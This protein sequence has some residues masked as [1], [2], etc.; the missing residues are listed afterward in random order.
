MLVSFPGLPIAQFFDHLTWDGKPGILHHV[1]SI[2]RQSGNSHFRFML[3]N[4]QGKIPSGENW[5]SISL[6]NG[7][8]LPVL[9]NTVVQH[10]YATRTP[11]ITDYC[12]WTDLNFPSKSV[13][14]LFFNKTTGCTQK[15]WSGKKTVSPRECDKILQYETTRLDKH[16]LVL[17]LH[18]ECMKPCI[19]FCCVCTY[20]HYSWNWSNESYVQGSSRPGREHLHWRHAIRR[21]HCCGDGLQ[22]CFNTR[23]KAKN[24]PLSC[25][26]WWRHLHVSMCATQVTLNFAW[27]FSSTLLGSWVG[28]TELI[29]Y[30]TKF[31]QVF[32]FA[33]FT[34]F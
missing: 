2:G 27:F 3:I 18:C 5:F 11:I 23:I 4:Y 24:V 33:N 29:P 31:S 28:F 19:C 10:M 13:H 26:R 15:I 30:S 1:M 7:Q 25:R 34:N 17:L 6:Q 21:H 16:L 9:W 32:N 12:K 20:A 8:L 14:T 22:P